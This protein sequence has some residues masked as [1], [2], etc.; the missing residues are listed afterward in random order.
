MRCRYRLA[1]AL[2]VSVPGV[3]VGQQTAVPPAANAFAQEIVAV[4]N[5]DSTAVV[6]YL[7]AKQSPRRDDAE[8][9]QQRQT[10]LALARQGAGQIRATGADSAGRGTIVHLWAER[11]RRGAELYLS[12]DRDDPA[13]LWSVEV[14]RADNPDAAL[15]PWPPAARTDEAIRRAIAEQV[16]RLVRADAFSGQLLVAKDGVVLYERNAGF[17]DGAGRPVTAETR[18][19]RASMGKMITAVAIAQLVERG[20]LAWTDTLGALLPELGWGPTTRGITIRQLLTHR[21]GLGDLWSAPGYRRGYEYPTSTEQARLVAPLAVAPTTRWTYSNAGY[22]TLAAIVERV[23]GQTFA[24]YVD[25]SIVAPAGLETS[26]ARPTPRL[27]ALRAIGRPRRPD[28]PFGVGARTVDS[29]LLGWRGGGAGGGYATA[30]DMVRFYRA[31][32]NGTLVT[33]AMA[34]TLTV[35]REPTGMGDEWY[36]YGFWSREERGARVTGHGGGG[37]GV[38]IC[39]ESRT[40]AKGRWT[41]IVLS[42]YDPPVCDNLLKALVPFLADK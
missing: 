31:L 8:H 21:G 40:I 29:T 3:A 34:D 7:A 24:D 12:T 11:L 13:R 18:F 16:D 15:R 39:D 28:D 14:L 36:G 25:A 20:R 17:A 38:G 19:H 26:P 5:R 32:F 23:S 30:R 35:P 22:E 27:L 42:N 9:A 10:L 1:V 6:A 4:I 41:V 37:S 33:P 2:T